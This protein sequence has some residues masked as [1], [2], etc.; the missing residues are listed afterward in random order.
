VEIVEVTPADFV[1]TAIR[2]YGRKK[3][4]PQLA[5]DLGVDVSTIHRIVKRD[6]IPGPYEVAL[7]GL[8]AHR[9]QEI[10]LEKAARKLVPR[11]FRKRQLVP[12]KPRPAKPRLIKAAGC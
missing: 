4:K 3:W 11:K 2:V 8:I 10:V 12:G 7:R 6:Q 5:R 1:Q 9:Q